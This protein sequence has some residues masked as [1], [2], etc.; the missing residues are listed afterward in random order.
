MTRLAGESGFV[1]GG[2]AAMGCAAVRRRDAEFVIMDPGEDRDGKAGRRSTRATTAFFGSR[3]GATARNAA[4]PHRRH[5]GG[6]VDIPAMT[7]RARGSIGAMSS[8]ARLIGA[9]DIDF[10]MAAKV[11]V[12]AMARMGLCAC[13]AASAQ[14]A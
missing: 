7:E 9:P 3:R 8:V 6:R 13:R 12:S 4:R 10:C 1:T 5:T 2:A 14:F 11:A